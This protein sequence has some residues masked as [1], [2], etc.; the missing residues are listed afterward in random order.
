MNI[1]GVDYEAKEA[2]LEA[3]KRI[4]SKL[5]DEMSRWYRIY[6]EIQG[7]LPDDDDWFDLEEDT[8]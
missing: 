1:D 6:D 4:L 5:A 8:D 7:P 2:Q 3:I